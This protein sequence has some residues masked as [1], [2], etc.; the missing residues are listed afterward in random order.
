[1]THLDSAPWQIACIS[2]AYHTLLR[3]RIMQG[4]NNAFSCGR[5][6]CNAM[7]LFFRLLRIK[8]TQLLMLLFIEGMND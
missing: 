5:E 1:M 4:V 3:Q 2:H 8:I 6:L 7:V